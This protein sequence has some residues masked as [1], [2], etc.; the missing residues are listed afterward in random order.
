MVVVLYVKVVYGLFYVEADYRVN[1]CS[2]MFIN[3]KAY[4]LLTF[5]IFNKRNI[6]ALFR[7]I[8]L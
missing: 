1:K 8:L 5:S 6:V 2:E 4:L 3:K 7:N